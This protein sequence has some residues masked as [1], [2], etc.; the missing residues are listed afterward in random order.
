MRFVPRWGT[1]ESFLASMGIYVFNRD[2]LLQLLDNDE[3]DFGKNI[4]PNSIA[5]RKVYSYIYDGYWKDIG[6]IHSFWETNLSLTD[7]VPEFQLLR[8]AGADLY[9]HAV[10]AA[11][12]DQ[13]LTTSI[14][15]CSPRGVS[16]PAT[17]SCTRLWASARRWV[18]AR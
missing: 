11:V 14:A 10:S 13:L 17:A 9:E 5:N 6:T 4:I 18:M 3:K 12:E 15:A 8:S 2:V 1:E 7:T 16:F